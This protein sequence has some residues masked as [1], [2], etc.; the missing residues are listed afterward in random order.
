MLGI[1]TEEY[2]EALKHAEELISHLE[3]LLKKKDEL[4]DLYKEL[5]HQHETH[6]D[7]LNEMVTLLE[8]RRTL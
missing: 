1:D 3:G 6:I 8:K 4:I 5:V 2:V 7:L